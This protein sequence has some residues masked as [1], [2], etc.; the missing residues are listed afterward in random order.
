MGPAGALGRDDQRRL[1]VRQL[2]GYCLA[3]R[4]VPAAIGSGLEAWAVWPPVAAPGTGNGHIDLLCHLSPGKALVTQLEGLLGRGGMRRRTA[5]LI[6][7][8]ARGGFG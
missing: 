6:V 4:R 2:Q 5:A 7:T 1:L 8:P 3:H